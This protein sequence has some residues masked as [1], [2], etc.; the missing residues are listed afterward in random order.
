MYRVGYT[1]EQEEED[2]AFS[3]MENLM[4]SILYATK[5][6]DHCVFFSGGRT[7][8]FRAKINAEYKA[9]RTQPKPKHYQALKDFLIA[10]YNTKQEVDQEADDGMGIEQ[11]Q[12]EPDTTIICSIDK[13]L[14]QIAGNHY[15]FVKDT[16][17]HITEEEGVLLF[18]KQLLMGDTVDNIKGVAGIGAAKAAK[19]LDG[20][21]GSSEARLFTLVRDQY[22]QWISREWGIVESDWEA[23]HHKQ[24]NNIML[25]N[26]ICL[27]I[28]TK[29]NEI[30]KFPIETTLDTTPKLDIFSG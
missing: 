30:W 12:S 21:L 20:E 14:L 7:E 19:L 11:S 23:F 10:T 24:L 13:D 22:I 26:G 17:H 9:N 27:K 1:T 8:T 2:I 4:Q 25:V 5:A 6:T 16:F 3:R 18:Y 15:N 28:R 29:E